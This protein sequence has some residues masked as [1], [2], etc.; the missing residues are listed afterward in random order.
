MTP[1][2]FITALFGEGWTESQL[3]VF[4]IMISA[5]QDDA[6]RY[7]EIKEVLCKGTDWV[8]ARAD[9]MMADEQIDNARRA[10]LL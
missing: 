8:A 5:M 3:P 2:E 1:T 10:G 4:A 7:H 6:K 9:L